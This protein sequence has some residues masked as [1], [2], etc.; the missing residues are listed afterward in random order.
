MTP[1]SAYYTSVCLLKTAIAAVLSDTTTAEGNILFDEGAQPSFVTQ[2]LANRL[3]L[4]PT[5][6]E[7]ISVSSFGAQVSS[8]RSLEVVTLFVHTLSDS[9]IPISALVVPKLAAPIRSSV[10]SCLSPFIIYIVLFGA[11]SSPFMLNAALSFHLTQNASPVSKD[12]L[13]D[14][15][16]DNVLSGCAT[17]QPTLE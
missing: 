8:P 9:R 5:H 16:V 15:Y 10:H 6:H 13:N 3:H 2:Q 17:E 14:L 1:L 7:T 11:T 4:Q 12:L